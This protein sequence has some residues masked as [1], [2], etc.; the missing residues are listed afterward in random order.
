M[1]ST[2]RQRR[3]G[4][5]R[6]FGALVVFLLYL[7]INIPLLSRYGINWDNVRH[8]A[9][10]QSYLRYFL[11]GQEDYH[12]LNQQISRRSYFQNDLIDFSYWKKNW[13]LVGH[14][15]LGEMA[16]SL[17]NLVFYQKLGVLGDT[18]AYH[19]Y[20]LTTAALTVGIVFLF[21]VENIGLLGSLVAALSLVSYPLF[22]GESHFNLKDISQAAFYCLTIYFFYRGIVSNKG[23][24]ILLSAVAAGIAFSTKFNILFAFLTLA[25]WLLIFKWSFFRSLKWPFNGKVTV[26]LLA[27]PLIVLAIFLS[28]WPNAIPESKLDILLTTINYYRTIGVGSYQ[29]QSF[30]ILGINTYAI[31]WI[32]YITPPVILI[33]FIIG[34]FCS[35]IA[36]K[37]RRSA[38]ITL[39]FLWFMVPL[40]R[41]SLPG[42]SIYGGVRQIIE[43]IPAMAI[44]AGIGADYLVQKVKMKRLWPYLLLLPFIFPLSVLIRTH[45]NEN[46][47]FNF[48][49]GGLHGA[50]TRDFQ[51]WGSSY[52]NV[53]RQ[54][55]DWLNK[56]A[57]SNAKISTAFSYASGS[58]LATWLRT[59]LRYSNDFRSGILREGEYVVERIQDWPS[60]ADN[61]YYF[62]YTK[63]VLLPVYEVYVD[64]VPVLSIWKNDLKHTKEQYKHFPALKLVKNEIVKEGNVLTIS[65]GRTVAL[66]D[67]GMAFSDSKCVFSPDD[68]FQT[69]I[70]AKSWIEQKKDLQGPLF[71]LS[72]RDF[73]KYYFYFFDGREAAFVRIVLGENNNCVY[74]DKIYINQ[75]GS[76]N[77]TIGK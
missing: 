39:I 16:A 66:S 27:C 46:L 59:D 58:I 30:F 10:G 8:F 29:A 9:R 19:F 44:L 6:V 12:L 72:V 5:W 20:T 57:E 74:L 14:P 51:D 73:P 25:I 24:F 23:K 17:T 50:Y 54:A 45:P 63:R 7:L 49:I 28:I 56:N 35:L 11:T 18:E 55:A 47:Y 77:R 38:F 21:T 65:L 75:L 2:S 42:T 22:F 64:K 31:Q 4:F 41:S 60:W 13:S 69:S 26:S 3:M 68:V 52:G 76:D 15:P 48:L 37:N 43:Y 1:I 33:Y 32:M 40:V 70:D 67:M 36:T 61:Y 71:S 34:L 53:Y 62:E